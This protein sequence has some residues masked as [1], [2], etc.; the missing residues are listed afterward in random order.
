MSSEDSETCSTSSSDSS[1]VEELEIGNQDDDDQYVSIEPYQFEPEYTSSEG[2]EKRERETE[3]LQL[4]GDR[5]ANS[6]W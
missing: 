6:D 4:R 2:S 3:E 5:L 1:L